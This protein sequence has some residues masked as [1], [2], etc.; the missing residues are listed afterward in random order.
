MQYSMLGARIGGSRSSIEGPRAPIEGLGRAQVCPLRAQ[1]GAIESP[2]ASMEGL[3]AAI[4]G[5][6]VHF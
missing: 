4:E 5:P 3:W 6:R 2:K 1:G